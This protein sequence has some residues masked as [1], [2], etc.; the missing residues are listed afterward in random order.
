MTNISKIFIAI[1][2]LLI[3]LAVV[4]RITWLPITIATQ[5]IQ[6]ISLVILANACLLLAILLKK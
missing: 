1:G 3:L 5:P 2:C 6:Y 4:L